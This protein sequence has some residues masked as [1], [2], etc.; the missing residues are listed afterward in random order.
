MGSRRIGRVL[1]RSTGTRSIEDAE[2]Y[3]LGSWNLGTYPLLWLESVGPEKHQP[4]KK[5]AGTPLLIL[6]ILSNRHEQIEIKNNFF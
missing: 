6:I 5:Y 4:Q 1:T 2:Y 3:L